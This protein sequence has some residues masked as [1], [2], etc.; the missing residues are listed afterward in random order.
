MNKHIE[1][2]TKENIYNSKLKNNINRTTKQIDNDTYTH[3]IIVI[4]CLII[5]VVIIVFKHTHRWIVE[6]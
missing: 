1:V 4:A 2:N 3:S 5:F 6:R